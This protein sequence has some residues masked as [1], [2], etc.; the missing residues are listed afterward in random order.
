MLTRPRT[1]LSAAL[2]EGT[3]DRSLDAQALKKTL[4]NIN[5]DSPGHAMALGAVRHAERFESALIWIAC[6]LQPRTVHL[7]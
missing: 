6:R 1:R 2:L 7:V 3:M 4:N 5:A